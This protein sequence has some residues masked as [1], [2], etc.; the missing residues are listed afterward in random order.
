MASICD[1]VNDDGSVSQQQAIAAQE[2]FQNGELGAGDASTVISA[3]SNNETVDEC[4]VSDTSTV[5]IQNVS[6]S[7][8]SPRSVDV[9]VTL[10]NTVTEGSGEALSPQIAVSVDG[11]LQTTT[12]TTVSPGGFIAT[13]VELSDVSPGSREICATIV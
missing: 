9:F 6:A 1:F 4:V 13:S 12:S 11:V 10:Q 3:E 5:S 8:F 7:S 2:A